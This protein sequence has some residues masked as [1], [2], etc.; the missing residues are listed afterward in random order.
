ML[1]EVACNPLQCEAIR[2]EFEPAGNN[3][4]LSGKE[5]L[6]NRLEFA[7]QTARLCAQH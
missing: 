2:N 1:K 6:C 5:S 3:R 7:G 4:I